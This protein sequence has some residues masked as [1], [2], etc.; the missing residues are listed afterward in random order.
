[1][2]R[3]ITRT[4]GVAILFI[5]WSLTMAIGAAAAHAQQIVEIEF[6]VQEEYCVLRHRP[7]GS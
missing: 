5:V 6:D 2:K 3:I 4:S 7:T 1:M